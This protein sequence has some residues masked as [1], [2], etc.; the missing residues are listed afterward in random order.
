MQNS[1][2]SYA[3]IIIFSIITTKSYAK[4]ISNEKTFVC[5]PGT[6]F[7]S[8]PYPGD[9]NKFFECN[10]GKNT[11]KVCPPCTAFDKNRSICYDRKVAQCDYINYNLNES[12]YAHQY[13][14]TKY[15]I[16]E[17]GLLVEKDCGP[18]EFYSIRERSCLPQ[19][20]VPQSDRFEEYDQKIFCP[21][22][23]FGIFPYPFSKGIYFKCVDGDLFIKRCRPGAV[24]NILTK[25]CEGDGEP[26]F[27]FKLSKLGYDKRFHYIRC[28]PYGTR[29]ET[30]NYG[31]YSIYYKRCITDRYLNRSDRVECFVGS[32]AYGIGS[33][34]SDEAYLGVNCSRGLS[35]YKYPHPSN[36]QKYVV[37]ENNSPKVKNCPTNQVFYVETRECADKSRGESDERK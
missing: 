30:C 14:P 5:L 25:F 9:C 34:S 4:T 28:S 31:R 36:W 27:K 21:K 1:L 24:Y 11:L 35:L 18:K 8:H 3:S 13:D 33:D 32:V 12:T 2:L 16:C 19:A 22:D 10:D 37:C 7:T 29:V 15:K 26:E 20:L 17:N 6:Y 23:L